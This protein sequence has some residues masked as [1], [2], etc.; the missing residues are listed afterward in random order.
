MPT[1]PYGELICPMCGKMFVC[2]FTSTWAYRKNYKKEVLVFCSW[3]C[4]QKHNK[5]VEEEAA[6]KA[7]G[8]NSIATSISTTMTPYTDRRA[9]HDRPAAD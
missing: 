1:A 9:E 7:N 2:H 6:K 8:K 5:M 3:G 4:M